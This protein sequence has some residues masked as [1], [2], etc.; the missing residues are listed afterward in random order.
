MQ[1]TPPLHG[2]AEGG[3]Q[4]SDVVSVE[5]FF[6]NQIAVV[7]EEEALGAGGAGITVCM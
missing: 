5:E 4:G 1:F 3:K 7:F 2:A 6:E